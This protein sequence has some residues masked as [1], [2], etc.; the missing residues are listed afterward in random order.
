MNKQSSQLLKLIILALLGTISMVLLFLNFP[1]PFLPPYLKV[2]FGEVPTLLAALIFS[3][4][5]GVVVQ[6]IKNLLYLIFTG[7]ADPVGVFANFVAGVTFV[8]P[9]SMIYHKYKG[10]KSLL[11]GLVVGTIIMTLAMGI[12]NYYVLLPIYSVFMGMD[13]LS[14]GALLSTIMVG[15]IP[16]NLIKGIIVSALFVPLFIKLKPWIKQKQS[17]FS[18]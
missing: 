12:L 16:F 18:S 15:V 5:A 7:A 17:I 10:D 4:M 14:S 11:S 9:I 8:V 1:L 6:L 13:D 2:D 3:P